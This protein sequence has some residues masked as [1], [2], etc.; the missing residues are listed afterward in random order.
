MRD[1]GMTLTAIAQ[2]LNDQGVK[3]C[4]H[5]NWYAST[6]RAILLKKETITHE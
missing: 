1:Q 6:V 3:T 4:N 5:R 2:T